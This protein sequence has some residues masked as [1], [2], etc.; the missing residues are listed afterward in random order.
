MEKPM[1]AAAAAKRSAARRFPAVLAP[2]V[3]AAAAGLAA[4]CATRRG[5]VA[6]APLALWRAD[7]PARTALVGYVE[8]VTDEKSPDYIPPAGRIA[9]FDF[10]GTLFCET[11]PTY[12][13]WMVF[14]HRVLDD[15]SH[16]AAPE[17]A[18]MART[19][20][21]TG[22]WPGL[23]LARERAMARAWKGM[24][25][26]ALAAYVRRFAETPQPGF[27]GMKRGE[28]F[29]RPMVEAVRFLQSA[30]FTVYVCSGT[31]RML[32][33]PIVEDGLS[34][35]PRQIIGSDSGLA[36]RAQNG[37]D[38]LEHVY[39][40]DDEL[41]LGGNLLVKNLQMN[42]VSAIEREIGVRPVLA[43][44]NSS[45]DASMLNYTVQNKRR[46][47]MA[48]MVLCDDLEREYGNMARADGM[49]KA[50]AE[51]GWTPVSMR[52]DWK[53]IYGPGVRRRR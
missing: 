22:R 23:S 19:A 29:Y 32:L 27:S 18:E 10:D 21:E 51:N 36:A 53:T 35:P 44:G 13:D 34:L 8:S 2:A 45:S 9:V 3:L 41:V 50:A 1:F 37:R 38:G 42:K 11:D 30:G 15:P 46:K 24:T 52:D 31:D 20:R 4:G 14:D 25:P 17:E 49:R 12:I 39:G 28:A 33:R 43:F 6:D 7:A 5:P 47:A 26:E 16:H 48:F 40:K